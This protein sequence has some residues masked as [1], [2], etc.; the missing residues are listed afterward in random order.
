MTAMRGDERLVVHLVDVVAGEHQDRVAGR[1]LDDVEVAQHRVGR[2]AIPLGQLAPRDVRLEQLDPALVAVQ[3]PRPAQADVVV[4]GAR[5][6]LGQDDDV[7]DPGVDAVGQGEVDDPVLAT[8]WD[9]RLGPFL[10]QDRQA[11]T[12]TAGEDDGHRPLHIRNASTSRLR[13]G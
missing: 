7:V 8:E 12:L 9:R 2:P 5:V 13:P 1:V 4:E 3:V 10:G 11:L 6:V